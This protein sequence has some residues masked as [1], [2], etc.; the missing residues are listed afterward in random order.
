MEDLSSS[1]ISPALGW[2]LW[3]LPKVLNTAWPPGVL[4]LV[5]EPGNGHVREGSNNNQSLHEMF[6]HS[7]GSCF[8]R[9]SLREEAALS[10]ALKAE[11]WLTQ[12][13]DQR[14]A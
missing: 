8:F 6:T 2:D 12:S 13:K 7:L 3:W 14:S 4:G 1:C 10:Q 11:E 9:A 5:E